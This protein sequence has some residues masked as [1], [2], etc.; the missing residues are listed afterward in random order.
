M[1]TIPEVL[2]LVGDLGVVGILGLSLWAFVKGK[3]VPRATVDEMKEHA[4]TQTEL[5]ATRLAAQI[6]EG[7][8]KAIETGTHRGVAAAIKEIN[9]KK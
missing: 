8:E 1:E 2:N 9:N 5:L 3:I 7:T 4:S 6:L